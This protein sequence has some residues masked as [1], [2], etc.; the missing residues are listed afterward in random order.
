[1]G[2]LLDKLRSLLLARRKDAS[3]LFDALKRAQAQ[4][5]AARAAREAIVEAAET[6]SEEAATPAPPLEAH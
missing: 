6:P 4:R 1:V 5:D 2:K 3:L